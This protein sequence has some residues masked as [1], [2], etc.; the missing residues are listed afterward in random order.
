M[1]RRI[2]EL[3]FLKAI[4]IVLMIAFHLVYFS[5]S[6][7]YAKLIVYTFHMP[8]FLIISGYLMNISKSIKALARTLLGYAI[9]YIIIESGYIAM[10]SVLPI[11]E[12]IDNLTVSVFIEKLF[13]HPIG[14]YW[15]LQTLVTCGGAYALVFR[16]LPMKTIS[17]VIL[18]GIIYYIVSDGLG[19]MT[20]ACPLYFLAGV[21][22]R[23]SGIPFTDVFQSS[24]VA[25]IAF[26]L[27]AVYPQNLLME[28]S[29]GVLMVFLIISGILFFYKHLNQRMCSLFLFLGRNTMPL[30]LFSPI[31][32]FLCK[33]LVPILLFDSTGLIFLFVSLL[34]CISG[35][36]AVE[37][38]M[39]KTGLSSYFYANKKIDNVEP[40]NP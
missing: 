17:K 13:M 11:R 38:A 7:P 18:L 24:S 22:V 26:A 36:L 4:F 32:T 34:I 15:Y 3:D 21:V 40:F 28:R 2:N 20:F 8:G 23:Q 35:S 30:F 12:H 29:G 5:E 33:P 6:Y 37:W 39:D 14:P 31:F 19:I 9:P 16:L 10:A 1:Q 25:I 27:L